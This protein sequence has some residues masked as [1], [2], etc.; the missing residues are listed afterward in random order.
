MGG[1]GRVWERGCGVCGC[2]AWGWSMWV[3]IVCV[4]RGRVD[5]VAVAWG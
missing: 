4:E 5:R 3:E 1:F 2:G